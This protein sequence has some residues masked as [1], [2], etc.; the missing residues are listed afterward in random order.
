MALGGAA[1]G[2]VLAGYQGGWLRSSPDAHDSVL[3]VIGAMALL[4]LVAGRRAQRAP[5]AQWLAGAGRAVRSWRTVPRGQL[6]GV[7]GWALLLGAF[8]GWDLLSFARQAHDLPTLSYM[9]GRLT[10]F[11][12]GRAA[13]FFAWL[14][15]GGYLATGGRRP[16]GRT[17]G[18]R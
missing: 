8:V 15:V 7:A 6:L 16:E 1:G 14:L 2:A 12:W 4:A 5:S 10:R 18:R 17:R 9:I 3:A 11:R 13:V